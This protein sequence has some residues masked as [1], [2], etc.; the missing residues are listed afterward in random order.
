MNIARGSFQ[1]NATFSMT[2]RRRARTSL[3]IIS[4]MRAD[5]SSVEN[6]DM[7]AEQGH[8]VWYEL[9]TTDIASAAAF[10]HQVLGWEVRDAST[11]R[12]AYRVLTA[13]GAPVSGLMALPPEGI[14]RGAAPRWA[15]YVAVDDLD[16]SVSR[17]TALG[18]TVY[19]PPTASNIG[20][21]AIVADPQTATL[22][23]VEGPTIAVPQRDRDRIGRVGWHEL[24]AAE[25]RQAFAFYEGLF[26]WQTVGG[27]AALNDTYQLFAMG[28]D[29]LGGM[30]TKLPR[31]PFP[32][33]LY[34]FNVA[35]LNVALQHLAALGGKVVQGPIE[36]PNGIWIAR[37]IDPQ[38][39]MF[40]VQGERP[41]AT[42]ADAPP[43]EIGWAAEWGGFTSRGRMIERR[44]SLPEPA[45][46]RP[47]SKR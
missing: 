33:W 3:R 2:C 45:A 22:A 23:L 18:G 13:D 34:Y 31:A 32:F 43:F 20:R 42:S 27:D 19:V 5:R 41:G 47:P 6:E 9:L 14:A 28:A 7:I 37:C 8:F 40:A 21:I 4:D 26:G 24:L 46:K 15:G 44:G 12:F 35:D 29:T 11:A 30:F 17:L 1:Q 38:G 36:Q 25:R 10:Y 39:A 16:A